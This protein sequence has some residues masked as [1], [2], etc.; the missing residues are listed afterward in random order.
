MHIL[1]GILLIYILFFL[2]IYQRTATSDL[3]TR[4]KF[5]KFDRQRERE[6]ERDIERERETEI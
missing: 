2:T 5:F 3:E 6:R 1:V 4:R